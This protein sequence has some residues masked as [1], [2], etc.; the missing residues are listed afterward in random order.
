M[1][2]RRGA[3]RREPGG[4]RRGR[5]APPGTKSRKCLTELDWKPQRRRGKKRRHIVRRPSDQ[6]SCQL[7][8]V[9]LRVGCSRSTD[10]PA[11]AASSQE[12]MAVKP[13]AQ[14]ELVG[15][16]PRKPGGSVGHMTLH[17]D[18]VLLVTEDAGLQVVDVSNPAAPKTTGSY[19][20]KDYLG[21]VAASGD[22]AY[23]VEKDHRLR[24]LNISDPAQ[25]RVVGLSQLPDR[26]GGLAVAGTHVYVSMSD[27]LRVLDVSKPTLPKEVGVCG[28]LELAGRV[29]VAGNYA[30]VAAN[31][32][33]MRI[34]DVSKPAKPKEIG[35]FEGPGNVTKVAVVDKRAYLADYAGGLYI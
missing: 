2:C 20:P 5:S 16:L 33:G 29:T 24:V 35:S 8:A 34:I 26:I 25:P 30:Y 10:V 9:S 12:T 4:R 32:N 7:L 11:E 13:K 3:R 18:H 14:L 15:R 19:R 27:S 31:F 17:G 28:G 22:H 6:L 21:P 23:L 1:R